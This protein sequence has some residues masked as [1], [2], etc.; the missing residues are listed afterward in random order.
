MNGG[1]IFE[2]VCLPRYVAPKILTL[3]PDG[4]R[5]KQEACQ[6]SHNKNQR[7][8]EKTERQ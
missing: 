1:N 8:I 2:C 7:D 5:E 4:N 3:K 6:E